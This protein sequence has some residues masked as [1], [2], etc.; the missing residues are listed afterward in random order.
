M[1]GVA[2]LTTPAAQGAGL[3]PGRLGVGMFGTRRDR[4]IARRLVE[5]VLQFCRDLKFLRRPPPSPTIPFS[6]WLA[7][8]DTGPVVVYDAE[9]KSEAWPVP[10][11]EPIVPVTE[12]MC[13]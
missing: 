11:A 7:G 2:R 4:G 3:G 12:P 1:P 9:K 13:P 10:V 5:P 8:L 6:S